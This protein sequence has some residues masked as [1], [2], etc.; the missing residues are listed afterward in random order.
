M[1]EAKLWKMTVK[2]NYPHDL[3]SV[4]SCILTIIAMTLMHLGLTAMFTTLKTP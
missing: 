2:L 3:I 1:N 4:G